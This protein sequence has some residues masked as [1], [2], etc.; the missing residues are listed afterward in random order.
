M[1]FTPQLF[2]SFGKSVSDAFKKD[3]FNT[4]SN[5]LT[6]RTK[7]SNGMSW[8]FGT[9]QKGEKTA[10]D[11]QLKYKNGEFGN[12]DIK[13]TTGNEIKTKTKFDKLYQNLVVTV[14]ANDQT[15]DDKLDKVSVN[16]DFRQDM[17]AVSAKVNQNKALSV[18]GVVGVDN[19]SVGASAKLS[20]ASAPAAAA[21]AK[22]APAQD[23]LT[24]YEIGFQYEAADFTASVV[25][26]K[27]IDEVTGSLSHNF[28]K[29]TTFLAQASYSYTD[30]TKSSLTIGGKTKVDANTSAT[31]MLDQK[32]ALSTCISHQLRSFAKVNLVTT[33]NLPAVARTG[34]GLSLTLGE[35]DE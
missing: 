2:S 1:S 8:T 35:T 9:Q 19:L 24:D 16:A 6:I 31:A 12:T 10:S 4:S 29:D 5:D 17:F 21:D 30:A 27:K 11:L 22:P 23:A 32:G 33:W 26:K 20:F 13:V 28:N 7:S 3:K 18:S 15:S 14:E 34:F 25:A